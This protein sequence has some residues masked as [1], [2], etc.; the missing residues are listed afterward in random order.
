MSS[1]AVA[2][3]VTTSETE[4]EPGQLSATPS[5]T[6]AKSPAAAHPGQLRPLA[7]ASCSLCGVAL[8]LGLLVPDGG[9]ACADIRWYCK[10]AR[11][12]TERW[13]AARPPAGAH[14][15]TVHG[16][17]VPGVGETAPDQAPA[18][19]PGG[20]LEEAKSAV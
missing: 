2:G 12:C 17:A 11:S 9:Q 1:M 18:E 8:P 15:P 5:L 14:T 4:H 16:S 20:I 19:R 3:L 7:V 10:D 6:V 13:T